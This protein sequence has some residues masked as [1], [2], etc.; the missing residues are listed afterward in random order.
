MNTVTPLKRHPG[1]HGGLI[2]ALVLVATTVVVWS[3]HP[4]ASISSVAVKLPA[5]LGVSAMPGKV[6]AAP[7]A[8][9]LSHGVATAP[10]RELEV[11]RQI[12]ATGFTG[13]DE[14][15]THRL[16]VPVS[17]WLQKVRTS[18]VGR[19][20]RPGEPLATI[21]S[22]E[23]YLATAAVVEQV[24]DFKSQAL[25]DEQRYRLR[26]FGMPMPNM[27][28]I[29]SQQRPEAVLPLVS[30]IAGTVV[31]EE[32]SPK[33]LV[34]PGPMFTITDPARA[35]VFVELDAADAALVHEG[36]P[37]TLTIEGATRPVTAPIAYV[38]RRVEDGK[39]SVRFDIYSPQLAIQ[40][41]RA[42]KAE[43]Q[44]EPARVP[45]VP[46]SAVRR[47]DGKTFVYVVHGASAEAREV[48]LGPPQGELITVT[49]N[50]AVG[51]Q[52]AVDPRTVLEA[53][54]ATAS[55]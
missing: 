50:L 27:Q 32:G 47:T 33:G 44:L 37:A 25:L 13:Y 23:V 22:P 35:W 54:T 20:V 46:A 3:A 4:R 55:P 2:A 19:Q 10:V 51:D 38:F 5:K 39:R 31:K 17:G 7:T 9:T 16:Q 1:S 45:A 15:R 18:S 21:V 43:L 14:T 24:K 11:R 26:R 36:A 28:R 8:F 52:V 12:T 42:V 41:E 40:P 29:E 30:R 53:T 48:T 34:E 49:H 6:E